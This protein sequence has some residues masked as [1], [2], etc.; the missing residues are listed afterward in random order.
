MPGEA[1]GHHDRVAVSL[2]T[3]LQAH[4]HPIVGAALTTHRSIWFSS[5]IRHGVV[6]LNF[7][8]LKQAGYEDI[9]DQSDECAHV[10]NLTQHGSVLLTVMLQ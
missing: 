2:R 5:I 7:A 3:S 9:D 4:V 8:N 1:L 10:P 6:A